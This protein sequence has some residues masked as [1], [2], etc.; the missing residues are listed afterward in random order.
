MGTHFHDKFMA[1]GTDKLVDS[2]P[3]EVC[4]TLLLPL[5]SEDQSKR[6]IAVTTHDVLTL[7]LMQQAM[8]VARKPVKMRIPA[9][10]AKNAKRARSLATLFI[11]H[12]LASM[13]KCS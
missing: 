5:L 10:W 6:E 4:S 11:L 9:H 3:L 12:K 1:I 2:A 13:T 8:R 7:L